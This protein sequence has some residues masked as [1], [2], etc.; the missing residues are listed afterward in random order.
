MRNFETF[1]TSNPNG[2]LATV[3]NAEPRTRVFQYLW[4]EGSR[5]YFCTSNRKDVYRQLQACPK[6]SFCTWNPQTFEVLSL[7]GSVHFVND[8][9]L[10]AKALDEN[11]PI[12]GIYQSPENPAFELFYLEVEEVRAFS[13]SEGNTVSRLE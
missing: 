13:F 3:E 11:P 9:R 8:A 6:A 5:A 2:V 12:K 10:K 1:L 4:K 7:D